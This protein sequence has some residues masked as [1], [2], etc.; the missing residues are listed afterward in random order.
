MCIYTH[1]PRQGDAAR[2]I[3]E[4]RRDPLIGLGDN[5]T[6]TWR[7]DGPVI[8][9]RA[10]RQRYAPICYTYMCT[11]ILYLY[12]Y[13]HLCVYIYIH[14]YRYIHIYIHT[15]IYLHIHVYAYRNI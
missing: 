10:R 1:G 12:I 11:Y 8:I 14:V 15:Y 5:A 13:I 3:A 6:A 9:R 2:L 7:Q 4:Q